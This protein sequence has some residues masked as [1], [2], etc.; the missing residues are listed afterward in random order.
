MRLSTVRPRHRVDAADSA[1]GQPQPLQVGLADPQFG[2]RVGESHGRVIAAGGLAVL[3]R[4]GQ[5]E[6]H[7]RGPRDDGARH[8]AGG[9]VECCV[10][11][12]PVLAPSRLVGRE[13]H[14]ARVRQERGDLV[15]VAVGDRAIP[16]LVVRE[17][18]EFLAHSCS[19]S[20]A[21]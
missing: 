19:K 1:P 9:A 2:G 14:V 16:Q 12:L 4:S 13:Q 21:S 3:R 7:V 8:G 17:S 5:A 15:P 11:A 18:R 6:R 10:L 20:S